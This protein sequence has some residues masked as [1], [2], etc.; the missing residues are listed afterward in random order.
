MRINQVEELTGI[1]G[2]NIRF[3]EEQGLLCPARNPSNS[4][5]DYTDEDVRQL[6][7]VIL[8]RKLGI[9]CERIKALFDGK[10]SLEE[11]MEAQK[12]FLKEKEKSLT[13]MQE[14]C[15]EISDSGESAGEI[16]ASGWLGKI[17]EM[18]RDGVKFPDTGENDVKRRRWGSIVSALA[19]ILLMGAVIVSVMWANSEAPIPTGVLVFIIMFPAACIIGVL[20]ALVQRIKELEKGE[21]YEAGKY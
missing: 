7:K 1:S 11:C 13:L 16:D 9:S 15:S 3:Y 10:V 5:R 8:F 12:R 21:M 17:S 14:V 4:Y 20:I 2:K 19:F 6:K 18:E